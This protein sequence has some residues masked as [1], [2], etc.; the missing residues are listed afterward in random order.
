MSPLAKKRTTR[1]AA[2]AASPTTAAA[3]AAEDRRE[4]IDSLKDQLIWSQK[5]ELGALRRDY[6]R[7]KETIAIQKQHLDRLEGE[8]FEALLR[9]N[10]RVYL[11]QLHMEQRQ[12]IP[13]ETTIMERPVEDDDNADD[14]DNAATAKKRNCSREQAV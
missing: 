9:A 10:N 5:L 13:P 11:Q 1:A 4:Q 14:A 2:A 12:T 8:I 6:E 7:Q 3:T